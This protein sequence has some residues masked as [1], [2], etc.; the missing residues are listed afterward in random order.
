MRRH[1][2]QI[3][4]LCLSLLGNRDEADDAAQEVFLSAFKAFDSFRAQ[5]AVSTWLHRITVNRCLDRLRKR[6]RLAEQSWD[7]LSEGGQ[8]SLKARLS[9]GAPDPQK[10]A[11]D[12][13]LAARML[14]CL[15]ESQRIVLALREAGGLSYEEIAAVLECS[16]DSVKARLRRARAELNEGLRHF[17]G[18]ESV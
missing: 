12:A 8:E 2:P 4:G 14:A 9:G 17:L 18:P 10:A 16:I 5:A 13:D 11:E 6:K 7:A 15:P 3:A 1:H